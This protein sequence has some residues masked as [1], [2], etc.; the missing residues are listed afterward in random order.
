MLLCWQCYLAW[1]VYVCERPH[2]LMMFFVFD[3]F[4]MC[5]LKYDG[6]SQFS[7]TVLLLSQGNC[8][9]HLSSSF[10]ISRLY[11]RPIEYYYKLDHKQIAITGWRANNSFSLKL[12]VVFSA[13]SCCES[14]RR[15][16]T[17]YRIRNRLMYLQ[18]WQTK[19]TIQCCLD[20]VFAKL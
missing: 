8:A 12:G 2:L 13:E 17:M 10:F 16:K 5:Y 20:R 18:I 7:R 1:R 11:A 9:V 19:R 14:L 15:N 6:H 3:I 4:S